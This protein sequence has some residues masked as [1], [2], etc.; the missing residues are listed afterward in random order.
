[1][2]VSGRVIYGVSPCVTNG[3]GVYVIV[4]HKFRGC[5]TVLVCVSGSGGMCV[6][7][8]S[9]YGSRGLT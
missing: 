2:Q 9:V 1:M 8:A 4:C 3:K 7:D 5:N 6:T